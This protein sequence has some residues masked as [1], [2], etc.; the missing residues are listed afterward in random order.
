MVGYTPQGRIAVKAT[1]V[2]QGTIGIPPAA[3]Q[4]RPINVSDVPR[5]ALRYIS[6]T[7]ITDLAAS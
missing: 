3:D 2:R 4:Q 1:R 6:V 7:P 5:S